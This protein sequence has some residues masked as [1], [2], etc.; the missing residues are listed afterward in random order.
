MTEVIS[1]LF[2]TESKP[3]QPK[4]KLCPSFIKK[5]GQMCQCKIAKSH[6]E[7]Y[8]SSVANMTIGKTQ[9]ISGVSGDKH[10]MDDQ[11]KFDSVQ[12]DLD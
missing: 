1:P 2:I 8:S 12:R 3:S 6:A 10:Q 11:A 7:N 5:S 4:L 9:R